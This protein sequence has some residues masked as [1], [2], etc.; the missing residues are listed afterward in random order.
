MVMTL[1][2]RLLAAIAALGAAARRLVGGSRTGVR[3]LIAVLLLASIV[4]SVI[5][6]SSKRPTDL[7]FDDVRYR[8]LPAMTSWYR[9]EGDLR[10]AGNPVQ[11]F[12]YELV[13][14]ADGTSYVNVLAP[15]ALPLGHTTVTGSVSATGPGPNG[16]VGWMDADPVAEPRQDDRF[17]LILIPGI[18][19]LLIAVGLWLGYPLVRPDRRGRAISG[20]SDPVRPAPSD[21]VPAAWA[22]WIRS[23]SAS[24]AE[25]RP[26]VVRVTPGPDVAQLTV[27]DGGLERP[28]PV[29]RGGAARRV[30]VW[31]LRRGDPGLDVRGAGGDIV[32]VFDDAVL[33]DRV[34]AALG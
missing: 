14:P 5:I 31:R 27:E 26:C 29:R 20:P 12:L 22:G 34:G 2:D 24:V 25:P 32:L 7:S 16:Y 28:V 17:W 3:V 33:R 11:P 9:L 18:L 8:R 4:P 19:G 30:R 21:G 10:T 23:E 1:L 15:S 6:G 13:D